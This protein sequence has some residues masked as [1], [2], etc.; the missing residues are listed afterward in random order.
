M[1]PDGNEA[2]TNY[3]VDGSRVIVHQTAPEFRLRDGN[4]VVCIKNNAW[5]PIG[6]SPGTGT[7]SPDVIRVPKQTAARW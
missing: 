3:T 1:N 2:A 4:S 7:I 6:A 5:N